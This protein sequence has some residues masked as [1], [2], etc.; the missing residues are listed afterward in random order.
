MFLVFS[1]LGDVGKR[2]EYRKTRKRVYEN[3]IVS[4]VVGSLKTEGNGDGL[5]GV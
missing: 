3:D 1:I 2:G 5:S 4:V